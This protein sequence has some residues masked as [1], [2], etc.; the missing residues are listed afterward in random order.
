MAGDPCPLFGLP[1]FI[2]VGV[3]KSEW[4]PWGRHLLPW[5]WQSGAVFE[6]LQLDSTV[7][8]PTEDHTVKCTC[9]CPF[10]VLFI[11]LGLKPRVSCARSG[12]VGELMPFLSCHGGLLPLH[13]SGAESNSTTE[14][15]L[16]AHD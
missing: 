2:Y 4:G 16:E 10:A 8:R 14:M 15:C 5:C 11:K 6:P 1:R 12:G 7:P 9:L 3:Y 13:G